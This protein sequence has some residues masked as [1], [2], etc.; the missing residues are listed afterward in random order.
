[1]K[2]VKSRW[3]PVSVAQY[4]VNIIISDLEEGIE[5]TL[6]LPSWVEALDLLEDGAGRL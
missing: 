3:R 2:A 5:P 4:W 6:G 1:M